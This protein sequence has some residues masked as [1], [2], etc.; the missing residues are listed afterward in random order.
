[1]S[2]PSSSLRDMYAPSQASWSFVPSQSNNTVPSA[3]TSNVP[4]TSYEWS[5]RAPTNPI[6]DLSSLSL[7]EPSGVEIK[8][9]LKGLIA[10]AVMQYT[11]NALA[12]P[13]EVGK[14]L[15]QVQWVPRDLSLLGG[16]MVK[17]EE[18]EEE[19]SDAE[20]NDADSYFADPS[21]PNPVRY[22]RPRPVDERGYVVRRSVM[23]EGTRPEYIIPV[24]SSD[25]VWGM[26]KRIGRFDAEGW[27]A[28]FKGLLTSCVNDVLSSTLQPVVQNILQ[29]IFTPSPSKSSSILLPVASHLLTGLILSPLDLVRTRL[30][31]Q[32]LLPR[33]QSYAGPLDALSQ[34]LRNEGG[35]KGVY[36]HPH[37][38]IPAILDNGLRPLVSL[39]LP[40]YIATSVL[41]LHGSVDSSP[42]AW[43]VAE[44]VGTCAGLIIVMPFETIRRRLQVQTRGI[45]KPIK[46]CVE[47]RPLP[48]NGVVDA[49]WHIIT[50]ERSN[51]PERWKGKG[52]EKDVVVMK[53]SWWR[54]M[55]IEQLYRGFGMRLTASFLVFVLGVTN[56]GFDTDSGWAEL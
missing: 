37:L 19:L 54:S 18:Y 43:A 9:L 28:L 1:M 7:T 30:I 32:S 29:S 56:G 39:A 2:A 36:L 52:K 11:S 25:G 40:P 44:L 34:I 33:Y 21:N 55:G 20:S 47:Q 26:V 35:L 12:M 4:Q 45:A 5:T 46:A 24:S 53:E 49:F 8:L 41:G 14:L 50:E 22:T 38:L 27:L 31:V 3:V 16:S 10:G 23:E 17:E 48:Y 13:F 6:F 15:L 51:L 42:F